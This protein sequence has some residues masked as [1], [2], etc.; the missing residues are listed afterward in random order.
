M[1]RLRF[2]ILSFAHIHAWSYARVLREL[3]EAELVAIYD[4]D[5][6]R[7]KAAAESFGV[8]EVYT[9]Y[10]RLLARDDIDAV[11]I[12]SENARHAEL[13]IAAA[14]AGKHMIVEKPLATTLRDGME[15]VRAAEK[16][17]VKLQQAFV[18]RYHDATAEVKRILDAGGIGRVLAITSTNH[19]KYPGLWFGDPRLA[20]GG[21]VMDHTVH[22]ADLMRWYTG[23][24]V[25]EVYAEVG[26]N[27]RPNL[28][29]EDNALISLRFRRGV[30]GSIDCSWSRHE[31]WPTWGDV[32]LGVIGTEGYV[33]VDA[34]RTCI[35]VV[36][37]GG[38]LRW[39]Y[40]GSDADYN[41][42]RDFVRVVL[43]DGVPLATGLDGYRAMEVALA[44]Y[45]SSRR[46]QPVKL[47]LEVG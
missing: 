47:P 38:P 30:L 13:A 35:N 1:R 39:V 6:A 32:W 10:A 17:R 16:A 5:E 27:I 41:M 23:D 7:L 22:T 21:A 37:N 42:I 25:E 14:E 26:V 15:M 19:G 20:G 24:E 2:A 34:F 12:A 45:E 31:G 36:V 33:V 46:R 44:A 11:V 3:A 9:D 28:Q 4:D 8:K 43:E 18:M 40:Y 29:V